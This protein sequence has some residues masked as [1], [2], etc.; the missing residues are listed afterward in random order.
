MYVWLILPMN[1]H[2]SG[3]V[4]L[5]WETARE[6]VDGNIASDKTKP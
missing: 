5:R 1:Q 4:A 3:L 2:H 6:V